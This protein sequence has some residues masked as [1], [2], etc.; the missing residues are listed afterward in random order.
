[1]PSLGGVLL[2]GCM[3]VQYI[4][5]AVVGFGVGLGNGSGAKRSSDLGQL[6][7][8]VLNLELRGYEL[9]VK[10]DREYKGRRRSKRKKKKTSACIGG[11]VR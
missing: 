1:V 5:L 3:Y 7:E 4:V 8:E 11:E 6:E 10:R 9:E 2:Y